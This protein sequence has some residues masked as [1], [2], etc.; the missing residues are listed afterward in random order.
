MST[1]KLLKIPKQQHTGIPL[2]GLGTWKLKGK[3]CEKTVQA[4]LEMGYRHIDTAD[5]YENHQEIGRAIHSWKREELFLVSKIAS[6]ELSPAAIEK[7]VPRFLKELKTDYLDLLLVHWPDPEVSLSDSLQAMLK[8]KENGIIRAVGLSNCVRAHLKEIHPF[9]F[10]IATNQIEIHP[11]LQRKVLVKACIKEG[12]SLTAYRPLAKG[13]FETDPV[14]QKI[15]SHHH[16]SPS[17]I[18]LRFLVQQ[19]IVA[20]PKAANLQHLENNLHIFDFKL[21]EQEMKEIEKLDQGKRFCTPDPEYL[22]E[23]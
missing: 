16:K 13:V 3:E 11:Y 22:I 8:F 19:D 18:A 21:S 15:G 10:P 12:I 9:H 20:I 1:P 7:A 23:D 6:Y 4:A 5:I 17:Q 2:I 14:L